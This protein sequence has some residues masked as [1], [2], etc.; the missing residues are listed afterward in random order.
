MIFF[1]AFKNPGHIHTYTEN[2]NGSQKKKNQTT[3]IPLTQ[4]RNDGQQ[5]LQAEQAICTKYKTKHREEK[6]KKKYKRMK[7]H[8][9]CRENILSDSHRCCRRH[10][11]P[12][13]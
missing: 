4:P 7:R 1:F 6:E 12:S 13:L 11:K 2:T 9:L 10:R 3:N 5:S 8:T